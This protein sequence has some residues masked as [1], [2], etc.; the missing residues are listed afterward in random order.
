MTVYI[1]Y[2][3]LDNLA[4]NFFILYISLVISKYKPNLFLLFIS[5]SIG[6]FF[7]AM[8]PFL[9][10]YN[11]IIKILLGFVMILIIKR[12]KNLK[13]FLLTLISFYFI[14]F[15]L[16]GIVLMISSFNIINMQNYD[17][18]IQLYPFCIFSCCI[19]LVILC[20]YMINQFYKKRNVQK[21][22][23]DVLIFAKEKNLKVKGYYD[24]GNQLYDPKTKK[25]MV[26]ISNEIYKKIKGDKESEIEIRTISGI[27]TIKTINISILIYF[28]NN[29]NKIYRTS[30]GVSDNFNKEYDLILHTEMI[31]E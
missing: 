2:V 22:L 9:G 5:A 3:F 25:P 31:G 4:I 23:Y 20:K 17:G 8:Y 28:E 18:K 16:A 15:S 6:A 29:D 12:Y 30:A 21:L 14:S 1:E 13:S 11:Y 19:A 7:S 26:I 10:K 27:K 24:S